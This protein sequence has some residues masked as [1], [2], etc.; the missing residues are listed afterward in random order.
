MTDDAADQSPDQKDTNVYFLTVDDEPD[1]NWILGRL[2]AQ[3]G[4]RAHHA[5]CGRDALAMSRQH[6]YRA[7]F[8][9]AKLPDIEGPL[10]IKQLRRIHKDL[11]IILISGY[12]FCDDPAV[13]LA[14]R[15]GQIQAFIAKPFL[16]S[17]ILPLIKHIGAG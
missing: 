14:R 17:E 5:T 3:C 10:L 13:E 9:D 7:V 12:F 8:V 1:I 15:R 16:H 6:H 2:I 4:F 11:F